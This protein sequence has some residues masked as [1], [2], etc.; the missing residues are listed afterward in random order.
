MIVGPVLSKLIVANGKVTEPF[1]FVTSASG[2]YHP[3][4]TAIRSLAISEKAF[5]SPSGSNVTGCPLMR[6][7]V[8]SSTANEPLSTPKLTA[9]ESLS[10]NL[11]G[12]SPTVSWS[13]SLSGDSPSTAVT[14]RSVM[15]LLRTMTSSLTMSLTLMFRTRILTTG[16][17][18]PISPSAVLQ[19]SP[20]TCQFVGS[21]ASP[22]SA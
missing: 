6:T 9:I 15:L 18:P 8:R 19:T 16:E 12:S 14:V 10:G 20:C 22:T 21:T 1:R 2:V 13:G 7:P 11:P 5:P 17:G 4:A 3:S